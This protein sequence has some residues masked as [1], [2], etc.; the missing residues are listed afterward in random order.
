MTYVL[1]HLCSPADY[2]HWPSTLHSSPVAIGTASVGAAVAASTVASVYCP[3]SAAEEA[4]LLLRLL[5]EDLGHGLL[6]GPPSSPLLVPVQQTQLEATARRSR[7][8][9]FGGATAAMLDLPHGRAQ[10]ALISSVWGQL[11]CVVL[12]LRIFLFFWGQSRVVEG[13]HHSILPSL[14]LY[15]CSF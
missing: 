4:I 7:S 12:E 6:S 9:R 1:L 14:P 8:G 2:P 3:R 10:G 13:V 5:R 11:V 15:I